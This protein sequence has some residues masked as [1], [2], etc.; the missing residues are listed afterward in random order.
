MLKSVVACIA[1][2]NLSVIRQFELPN[3]DNILEEDDAIYQATDT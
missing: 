1:L 3:E 2:H